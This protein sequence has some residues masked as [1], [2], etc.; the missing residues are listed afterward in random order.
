MRD[1]VRHPL[2]LVVDPLVGDSAHRD[3]PAIE[4]GEGI[5]HPPGLDEHGG[6]VGKGPIDP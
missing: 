2:A 1:P 5:P 3:D 6:P 4:S